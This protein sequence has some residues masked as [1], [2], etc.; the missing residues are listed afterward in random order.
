[1]LF[2]RITILALCLVAGFL[3]APLTARANPQDGVVTAGQ[4]SISEDGSKLDIHQQSQKAIIDWRS[5]DI[6]PNEHTEFHQPGSNAITLNRV[7]SQSPSAINGKLTANGNVII[8]NQ[9]GVM[10]GNNAVID[11]NGLVA[12]TAD[13]DNNSFME[14]DVLVFD[15]PGNPNASV[16]NAGQITAKEAGLVGLVAPS[17]SNQGTINAALGEVHLAS[18]NKMVVDFYGDGLTGIEVSDEV[19]T[20]LVKN[21][22]IISADGGTIRLTAAAGRQV[23]DSLIQVEGELKAPSVTQRNGKIIISGEKSLAKLSGNISAKGN[24]ALDGGEVKITAAKTSLGAK[25]NTDGK[26]GG[27]ISVT[28]NSLSAAEAISAKGLTESGG[29]ITLN[30]S[31]KSWETD[32]ALYD[33]S[34]VMAGGSIRHVAQQQLTTSGTYLAQSNE[35]TG[36]SIAISAWSTKLLGATVDASGEN[37]GGE[38]LLGGEFQGGKHLLADELLNAHY[39]ILNSS[40]DIKANSLGQHGDGGTIIAWSDAQT[41]AYADISATPGLQSG[42]GGFVEISSAEKLTMGASVLTGIGNR[43]GNLLLD[44]KNIIIGEAADII[45]PISLILGYGYTV[46]GNLNVTADVNTNDY[47][48]S[49]VS[50]SGTRLAVGAYNGDGLHGAPS[51]AGEVYLF[52]FDDLSFNGGRL[53]AMVGN[54]YTGG[55]NIDVGLAASDSF[56]A[57]VS[58]DGNRLAVGA[59]LDDGATDTP[60]GTGAVYLFSFS[61]GEFSDGT[62][63]SIIGNGYVGGKNI[64]MSNLILNDQFGFSV[65]LDG[66]RLAVGSNYGDGLSDSTAGSG[67]VYLFTFSDSVFSGGALAATIGKGYTGGNNYDLSQLAVNDYFG[68]SVSL[69]GNRLAVGAINDDGGAP[70]VTNSGAVYLFS[71]ADSAF[72]TPTLQATIGANYSGGKNYNVALGST[73]NFGS[74]VSLDGNRLAVGAAV[75]D[76]FGNGLT[77]SGEVYLF[78]FSDSAFSNATLEAMI[79]S[80]YVGAKDIAIADMSNDQFGYSVSL[81]GNRLA[82]GANYDDGYGDPRSNNGAVYLFTFADAA[83]S[84][85]SLVSILGYGYNGANDIMLNGLVSNDQFG[86]SASLDGNRLAV[87]AS[88]DDGYTGP[89]NSGGVHLFTFDDADFN[90]ARLVALVGSGYTGGKN[91]DVTLE[92]SDTFGSGVSLDGNRLA[93]GAYADDGNANASAGSGAVYL[94]SFS[95]SAFSGG[96][97][98]GIIGSGYSGGKNIDLS[99]IL[100]DGDQFGTNLSLDGNRLAVGA[101]F[102]DSADNST[103]NTGAVYLFSFADSVFSSGTLEATIGKGYSGGKNYD[104]SILAA[105]DYFGSAVSLDGN[106]LAIGAPSGDGNSNGASGSGDV[107]LFTFADSNFS[108]PTLAAT[109][110][111]NYTGGNNINVSNLGAND[112]LGGGISLEGTRLAVGAQTDDGFNDSLLNS[113]AVYL[114]DFADTSF[115]GGVQT[116]IIGKDYTGGNNIDVYSLTNTNEN[117]GNSVS[118]NGGRLAIGAYATDGLNDSATGSG[119]VYLFKASSGASDVADGTAFATGAANSITITPDS[120]TAI[121]NAGTNVTLQAS[122]DI[123][124]SGAITTNNPGGDGGAIT[125]QAGRSILLNADIT[126]D[127]GNL[128]IYANEDLA[129][130]VQDAQRDAGA[131]VITM[132]SGISINAGTGAVTF[133]L[134]NGAGKT[135][136]TAGDITLRNITAGSIFAQNHNTSGDIVIANGSVL[137]ASGAGTPITLI[138]GRNF[139]NSAGSGALSANSGRWLVYSTNPANDTIGSLANDFRRFSCTYGGSC[140]TLG[141]DNGLLYSYTPNLTATPSAINL[142]YGDAAPS[143]TG[144]SYALSGYLGSDSGDDIIT[145]SVNGST[146]YDQGDGVGSY[147]VNYANNSLSSALGYGFIYADNASAITVG[148]R[149]ITVSA[150][151]QTKT[152]GFG[153]N[154]AALGT[155]A[156]SVSN[157]TLYGSDAISGVTLATNATVSGGGYYEYNAGPWTLTPSVAVFSTGNSGNYAITYANAATGLTINKLALTLA[158]ITADDKVYDR[159]AAATLSGYSFDAAQVGDTISISG[160]AGVFD[161]ENAGLRTASATAGTLAG[162]DAGNYDFSLGATT[163]TA[164]ITAKALTLTGLTADNKVYDALTTATLSGTGILN[165]IIGGDTVSYSAGTADFANKNVG[166]GKTVTASGFTLTGADAGNYSLTQ[167]GTWLADITAKAL[168]ITGVTGINKIYDATTTAML[169]NG[170]AALSGVIIGDTV[171]LDSTGYS[172]S[173]ADKDV[174]TAKTITAAGYTIN[175][176]DSGNYSLTQPAGVTADITAKILSITGITGI[177]KIYDATTTAMLNNGSAAL[178]GVII[179]DTVNLDS[180]GYS[181]SFADKDV[182]TAKSITAA[183]YTINGADSGNY[184]LTQPAGVTA[185][186]TAQALSIDAD[187]KVKTY[188]AADPAFTYIANGLIGGDTVSGSLTRTAGEDVG[189]YAI[190]LGS[191]SAGSNY[192]ITYTPANLT[193]GQ[194]GLTVTATNTSKI[195]GNLDPALTYTY[196]GLANG[197]ASATFTGALARISG[198]STGMYNILQNTLAATGNY[199]ISAYVAGIFTIH[200]APQT[201]NNTIVLPNTV[202]QASQIPAITVANISATS[203]APGGIISAKPTQTKSTKTGSNSDASK[204]SGSSR[205]D[206]NEESPE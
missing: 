156:F 118:L 124:V 145:G 114:F 17:V 32:T 200:T 107:Y 48:G 60:T 158:S 7:N 159:T 121:L 198:E 153:G 94:F 90:D 148:Q 37:G 206:S 11:V 170:S 134:D 128:N 27:S 186:I 146:D 50:L 182:G 183:G 103:N 71:F 193:I 56:G 81:D 117:F 105:N 97:L 91:I 39:L 112:G 102:G 172:A 169:N 113:G 184:S 95:D 58:L 189:S 101:D 119:A 176:A 85:G 34:G 6:A 65:S 64:N 75:G 96:A 202:W 140:P 108:T 99:G 92:A 42:D 13:T 100:D 53:T 151:D 14:N 54:G 41:F 122:N 178:S 155:S 82:V 204:D 185:D 67:D 4:A 1:M 61:D 22:G 46:A 123:T 125:L 12:T 24:Q 47:F 66:N 21:T 76:G 51:N 45:D 33:V 147:F 83:F 49:A 69:D 143:L 162:A 171:N 167:P 163:D 93:V 203:S 77:N 141:S 136:A 19:Q 201:S 31:Q 168:S 79:G 142:T 73:D 25:L 149:A 179:G 116:A 187:T 87:G 38:I 59:H 78:S 15:K 89:S 3:S 43:I 26:N 111:Y 23:V 80:S 10:F 157:G 74:S 16:E 5:F 194:A 181:A 36:G 18:G 57:S 2:L 195:V 152:Y 115:T 144:Y 104:L 135:N 84:G 29:E 110:G 70:A 63:E 175:G 127:N 199:I 129:A 166:T 196:S 106:R 109:L 205:S 161:S 62:L 150:S 139:V 165:G 126:T 68:S 197:D 133:R 180:T 173:F 120:L 137:S 55:K 72:S 160:L 138:S 190:G 174:G 130:G 52:S 20:Q 30:V 131:A 192:T 86:W 35:G 8:I 177:N 28:T 132:A 44:P 188:G 164:N 88:F 98:E 9:N 191:L 154:S 40:A